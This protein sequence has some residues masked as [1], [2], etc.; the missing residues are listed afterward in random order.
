MNFVHGLV[1]IVEYVS[2][3]SPKSIR[4]ATLK[5]SDIILPSIL[6]SISLGRNYSLYIAQHQIQVLFT[7]HRLKSYPLRSGQAARASSL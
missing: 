6:M 5:Q 3:C 1:N 4:N 7:A 2:Y